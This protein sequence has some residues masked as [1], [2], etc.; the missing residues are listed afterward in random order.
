MRL[1]SVQGKGARA[2]QPRDYFAWT[3]C[4]ARGGVALLGTAPRSRGTRRG[5]HRDRGESRPGGGQLHHAP[6]DL[7][8]VSN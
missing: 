6:R 1:P 7:Q 2:G 4:P 8:P 5:A 3:L